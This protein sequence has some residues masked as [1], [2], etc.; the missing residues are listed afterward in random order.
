MTTNNVQSWLPNRRLRVCVW[1]PTPAMAGAS[2]LAVEQQLKNLGSVQLVQL[3]SLDDP[4]F[5]PCDLLVLT[6]NFIEEENFSTWLK[7]VETRLQKQAGI[8]VPAMI[9]SRVE[10]GVQRE[11]LQWAIATNWYFDIVDPDHLHS[12]PIRIAN[13]L[14]LHDHL[15]EISRMQK[16]MEDLTERVHSLE[17][18]LYK[19]LS[20]QGH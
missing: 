11:L 10:Q 15:H 7:G 16:T 9:Y 12:L 14:R 19:A 8:K 2:I 3:K 13:F 6:A 20:E 18:A 4:E 1:N 5:H 17:Q